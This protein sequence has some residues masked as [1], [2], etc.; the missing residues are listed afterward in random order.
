[1]ESHAS[2]RVTVQLI[3]GLVIVTLGILFTLDNFHVIQA[4]D[5][6]RFWPVVLVAIGSAQVA[7]ARSSAR[8]VG[9][10]I[11]I[12][13]GGAL[14][15]RQVGLLPGNMRDYWPL[16]LVL[17]GGYVVWQSLNRPGSPAGGGSDGPVVSAVAILSGLNRRVPSAFHGAELTAFMGGGKLDLREATIEEGGKAVIDVFAMMGGFEVLIP[18]TWSVRNE[19]IPFMGGVDDKTKVNAGPLAP[20]VVLRG[21]V[22]WGGIDIKNRDHRE[23]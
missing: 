21:F 16:F 1:M 9:G 8:V 7:Q 22:M 23:I 19:V 6:L 15:G 13:L 10:G 11:W 18:E 4:R 12:L 14:L 20:V 3:L 2:V 17:L 5:Y